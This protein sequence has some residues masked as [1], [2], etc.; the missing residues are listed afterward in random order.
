MAREEEEDVPMVTIDV[1]VMVATLLSRCKQSFAN[2]K[3]TLPMKLWRF[4]T[5]MIDFKPGTSST[6]SLNKLFA[7]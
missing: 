2:Q 5:P 4:N 7:G 1:E 6:Y 3:L